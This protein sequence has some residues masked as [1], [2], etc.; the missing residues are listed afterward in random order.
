MRVTGHAQDTDASFRIRCDGPADTFKAIAAAHAVQ[1]VRSEQG[2]LQ[3]NPFSLQ[4]RIMPARH[5]QAAPARATL[6]LLT[7]LAGAAT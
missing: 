3:P 2:P 7:P 1:W 5:R 4:A 6:A